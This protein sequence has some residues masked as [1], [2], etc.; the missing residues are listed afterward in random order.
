MRNAIFILFFAA[1]PVAGWAH[2][3]H[4]MEQMESAPAIPSDSLHHLDVPLTD[5]HGKTFRLADEHAPAT[6]LTMFYGDC[7]IACPIILES[8]KRTID[9]LPAAQRNQARALLI[10]LNPGIDTPAKLD[11]LAKSHGMP[12]SRYRFAVARN[13]EQTRQLAAALG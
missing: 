2:D 13:D 10:S 8:V 11:Q 12:M 6:L 3:H 9:A 7:Q 1:I 5:Q 4:D